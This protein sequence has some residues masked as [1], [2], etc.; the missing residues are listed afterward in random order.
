MEARSAPAMAFRPEDFDLK[1][2]AAGTEKAQATRR[3]LFRPKVVLVAKP[4]KKMDKPPEPPPKTPEQLAE[5]AARAELTQIKLVGVVFRGSKGQAY[6]TQGDQTF[7]VI[8]GDKVGNRF[9]VDV[10]SVNAV[11]LSDSS[12]QV[13][14]T[15]VVSGN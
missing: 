12:T 4:V 1:I 9:T 10:I 5:E 6:L 14:G 13:R 3:D 15:I 11:Q 7:L 8:V 2:S